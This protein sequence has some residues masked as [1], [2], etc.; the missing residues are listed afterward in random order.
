[1]RFFF[2]VFVFFFF[3]IFVFVFFFFAVFNSNFFCLL[4]FFRVFYWCLASFLF[5]LE[6][7]RIDGPQRVKHP[8]PMNS[9][10]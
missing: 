6:L 5:A 8:H 9:Q 1:M 3:F 7:G 4:C 2:F 10:E